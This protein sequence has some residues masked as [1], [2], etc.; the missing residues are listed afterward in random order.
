MAC[1]I[2]L[3]ITFVAYNQSHNREYTYFPPSLINPYFCPEDI[4]R[5]LNLCNQVKGE[6][7]EWLS[8]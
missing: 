1:F 5:Y 8:G 3:Q 2:G 7:D 6:Y 4:F